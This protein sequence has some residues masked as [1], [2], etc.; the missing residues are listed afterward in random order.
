MMGGRWRRESSTAQAL[1][2]GSSPILSARISYFLNLKGPCIAIDTACSSS[3]VAIAQ[4][5]DSL[6]L[7]SSDVA[8]AGGVCVVVGPRTHILTSQAGMLSPEGR[9]YTFDQRADGYVPG[10]GVG[11]VMLKRLGEAERDGDAIRGVIR[12]W[13]INQDGKTNGITAPSV[14]SQAALEGEVYEGFGIDPGTIGSV[15]AHGTG[16]KLGDPIEVEALREAFGGRRSKVGYCAL[17]SV[18][19]EYRASAG[20]GGSVW[21]DQGGAGGGEGEAAAGSAF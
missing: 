12:G 16:T 15:E 2:G 10:E 5:C 19:A 9:C 14:Q 7:G 8:L 20:S 13:G 3:L 6:V 1:L 11:V 21:A 17:G 18:K 4:A